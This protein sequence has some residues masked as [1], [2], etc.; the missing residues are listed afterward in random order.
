MI[1]KKNMKRILKCLLNMEGEISMLNNDDYFIYTYKN[2]QLFISQNTYTNK[3]E[4]EE[5]SEEY[6]TKVYFT[7]QSSVINYLRNNI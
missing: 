4:I 2:R 7:T 1:L 5:Y 6:S 3:Y